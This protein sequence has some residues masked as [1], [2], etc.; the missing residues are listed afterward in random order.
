MW[1]ALL[2]AAGLAQSA[3]PPER[4]CW[5]T[6]PAAAQRVQTEQGYTIELA[7]EAAN[8]DPEAACR[9]VVT[10]SKGN[11]V[12]RNEGYN[13]RI[14]PDSG[15]D[16]DNDGHPDL[17]LGTDTGGGNRCCWS[18]VVFSLEPS[19]HVVTTLDNPAFTSDSGGRTVIWLT[20]AFYGFDG[21]SMAESPSVVAAHQFRSGTMTDI[22]PEY[23][24]AILAGRAARPADYRREVEILTPARKLAS[25]SGGGHLTE[26]IRETRAAAIAWSLQALSC[27]RREAVVQLVH[28]VWPA[29]EAARLAA[30]MQAAIGKI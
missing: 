25:R 21:A 29:A 1:L 9:I 6:R 8:A 28:D 18:Y 2:L 13:T 4:A 11:V 14:H 20:T 19:P 22:T 30:G 3:D 5:G 16:V 24:D 10:D 27:G 12:Y 17:I 23:C 7:S 26:E 15:R